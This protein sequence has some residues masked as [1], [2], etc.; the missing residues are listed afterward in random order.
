MK[1]TVPPPYYEKYFFK[2]TADKF[3][4]GT[5]QQFLTPKK[6]YREPGKRP[7]IVTFPKSG[8]TVNL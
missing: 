6:P 7:K 8:P 4:P 5:E 1:T 2:W 3:N